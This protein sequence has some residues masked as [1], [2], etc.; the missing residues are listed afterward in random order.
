VN[1]VD[2]DVEH[3]VDMDETAS[4]GFEYETARR[5]TSGV[6]VVVKVIDAL[7]TLLPVTVAVPSIICA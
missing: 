1:A 6:C 7:V 4:N 3:D 5:R 2:R